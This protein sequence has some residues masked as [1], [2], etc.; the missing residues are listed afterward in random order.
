MLESAFKDMMDTADRSLG[1]LAVVC[2]KNMMEASG[3]AATL[4]EVMKEKVWL[5]EFYEYD[6]DPPV[7]WI[8]RVM[9]IRDEKK[10]TPPRSEFCLG[11]ESKMQHTKS[12]YSHFLSSTKRMAFH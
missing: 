4:A 9:Y 10:G 3:Y 12:T 6:Q 11:C 2:D 8:D 7:K 1:G 5:V